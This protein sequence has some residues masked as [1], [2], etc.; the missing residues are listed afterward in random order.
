LA[1]GVVNGLS[2]GTKLNI[3]DRVF[4]GGPLTLRGFNIQGVG[5]HDE[6]NLYY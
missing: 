4:L 1:A 2:S 5:P 6:G 3:M